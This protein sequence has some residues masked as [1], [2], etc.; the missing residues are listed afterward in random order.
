M[1]QMYEKAGIFFDLAAQV[2]P[3]EVKWQLMVA[4]CY[5]RTANHQQVCLPTSAPSQVL[6]KQTG[7]LTTTCA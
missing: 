5:R 2:Q 7:C 4:S 6:G 3:Q 1:L